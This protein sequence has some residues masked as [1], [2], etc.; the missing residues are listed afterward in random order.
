MRLKTHGTDPRTQA[1][2]IG[3]AYCKH[4]VFLS[5]LNLSVDRRICLYLPTN[6]STRPVTRPTQHTGNRQNVYRD[7]TSRNIVL[8]RPTFTASRN[9]ALNDSCLITPCV[10]RCSKNERQRRQL[11]SAGCQRGGRQTPTATRQA[12]GQSHHGLGNL[13]PFGSRDNDRNN[14]NVGAIDRLRPAVRVG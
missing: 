10:E 8:V 13:T 12:Y 6:P 5:W 11:R 9:Q 2:K 4:A 7:R 3:R 14:D 1:L